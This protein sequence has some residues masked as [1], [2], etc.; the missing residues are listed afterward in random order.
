MYV[1]HETSK[2]FLL[3]NRRHTHTHTIMTSSP[4]TRAVRPGHGQENGG[5][6]QATGVPGGPKEEHK[7]EHSEILHGRQS[8]FIQEA[9]HNPVYTQLNAFSSVRWLSRPKIL[10]D[11]YLSGQVCYRWLKYF[12]E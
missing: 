10:A 7:T 12:V 3:T 1:V 6:I 9:V 4:P 8:S 2:S 5:R 11:T